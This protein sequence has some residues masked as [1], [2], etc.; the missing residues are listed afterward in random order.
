MLRRF[1]PLVSGVL[2]ILFVISCTLPVFAAVPTETIDPFDYLISIS[3][4]GDKS[5]V[6]FS[7]DSN[8]ITPYHRIHVP[9]TDG[10]QYVDD[11]VFVNYTA[12]FSTIS[13]AGK[14]FSYWCFPLGSYFQ[15]GTPTPEGGID[16]SGLLNGST[17]DLTVEYDLQLL[18]VP[19]SG[20]P[21]QSTFNHILDVRQYLHLYDANGN[22][23]S[24]IT[25]TGATKSFR[26]IDGTVP[27]EFVLSDTLTVS[28]DIQ[29]IIPYLEVN[30]SDTYTLTCWKFINQAPSISWSCSIDAVEDDS[31]LMQAINSQLGD[32]GDS[33]DDISSG[34]DSANDKLDDVNDN[35]GDISSGIDDVNDNLG[36]IDS[37]IQDIND[38]LTQP[39]DV[40]VG[41]ADFSSAG[42]DLSSA[43]GDASSAMGEAHVHLV[44]MSNSGMM[45]STLTS[46]SSGLS[47]AFSGR[48][49]I[50]ICGLDI[51]PFNLWVVVFGGISLIVLII[52]YIFRKRGGGGS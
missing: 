48:H 23:V 22:Y 38:T 21:S 31:L 34:I 42:D 36:D 13:K 32:I 14:Q 46:L 40:D 9:L 49:R 19:A 30:G 33:L 45:A 44:N 43:M 1:R 5:E 25:S 50:R 7:L 15:R 27:W 3:T 37:S 41:K 24:T 26:I 29:Y 20:G 2:L 6:T 17:I 16:V 4:S 8:D 47:A 12:A 11:S 35:L 51:N 10:T 52:N 18:A 39:V 28:S